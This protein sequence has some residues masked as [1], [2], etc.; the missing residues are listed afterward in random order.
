MK[1]YRL[2]TQ[3]LLA[4]FLAGPGFAVLASGADAQRALQVDDYFALKS[5]GSPSVSPDGKWVAHTVSAQ[6]L[7]T[8]GRETRVWM[9]PIAGGE[10][11]PM[12][13]TGNSAW[14]PRWSP[15][16]KHLSFLSSRNGSGVQVF[17]LDMRGG[18]GVQLTSIEQGVEGYEW[19]PDGSKLVLVIRDPDPD[20]ET[21]P[22]VID[23][24]TFKA[25]YVGYLNRQR[26]HIHVYDIATKAAI[27]VTS[28]DFEDYSPAWSPDSSKIVFVSN[29][30]AEPDSNENSDIWL[31]NPA[32]PHDQQ[33]PVRVTTNPGTD[34]SPIWHP[35]GERIGYIMTY[36]DRTDVPSAYLQSKVAIISVDDD[37]PVLLTTEALDRKA[38]DPH[39]SPD[40]NHIYVMLEDDGQ[41][42][43]ASVSV[44]D[45]KFSRLVTGQV[46]VGATAVAPD[47]SVVV[48]I[49]KPRLPGDLFV[50]DAES[51][52]PQPRRLTDVN[53]RLLRLDLGSVERGK[54]Q[55]LHV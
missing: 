52:E 1:M 47:G 6:D 34:S 33:E 38:Y 15:D 13:A 7:E 50:L 32:K 17:T 36:T 44:D 51:S 3:T 18:E 27:Q 40:G 19:S 37:E 42:Q 2:I 14:S 9:V 45:G 53:G 39:F 43:L 10:A 22:W 26:S 41:V 16:G 35:D 12:T 4:L 21:I 55:L 54:T 48:A 5:V 8:D 23:R 29:R 46:R 28:G 31:V 24:L 49:S 25:D 20:S 11:L 30:T